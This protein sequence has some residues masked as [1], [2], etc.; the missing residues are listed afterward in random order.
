[1]DWILKE[2]GLWN[3]STVHDFGRG[4]DGV[5]SWEGARGFSMSRETLA[6]EISSC[7]SIDEVRRERSIRKLYLLFSFLFF[8]N[9]APTFA[10]HRGNC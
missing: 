3:A 9:T 2:L 6:S 10:S 5:I 4:L 8:E 7:I 1:M